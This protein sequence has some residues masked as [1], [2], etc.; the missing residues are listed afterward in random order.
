MCVYVC[1]SVSICVSV[2]FCLCAC[3]CTGRRAGQGNTNPLCVQD[4]PRASSPFSFSSFFLTFFLLFQPHFFP[5]SQREKAIDSLPSHPNPDNLDGTFG[6]KPLQIYLL[7]RGSRWPLHH[8]SETAPFPGPEGTSRSQALCFAGT[9]PIHT[10]LIKHLLPPV[11][12]RKNPTAKANSQLLEDCHCLSLLS[13][14]KS[15]LVS[16][17]HPAFSLLRELTRSTKA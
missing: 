9:G 7:L 5:Q 16:M 13:C 6:S 11:A 8:R 17:R 12:I 4:I 1:G 15:L 10:P 3:A 2:C 14:T